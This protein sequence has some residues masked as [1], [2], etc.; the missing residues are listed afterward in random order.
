MAHTDPHAAPHG[1][2]AV[3]DASAGH[4]TT[5]ASLG[6]VEKFLVAMA[7]FLAVC[8]GIVW[9]MYGYFR[10]REASLDVKPSPVVQRSG[11]RLP[12]LP[13]LQTTPT[14]DLGA[15]RQSEDTVLGTWAWVDKQNGIA[16]VP[17]SRAI[18][19][20]AEKGLPVPP[21]VVMPPAG[22]APASNQP[23]APGTPPPTAAG[24]QGV[25]RKP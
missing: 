3:P 4:E 8:F 10:G 23:A 17:V 14:Q 15:F 5:D 2:G 6:G 1:L 25:V 13:R 16:Q 22:A 18:E 19:I 11:D 21:P 9:F 24:P 20:L 7:I 12:P